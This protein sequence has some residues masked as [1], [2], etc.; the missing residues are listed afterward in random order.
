VC[1]NTRSS[2]IFRSCGRLR[3][4]R[5]ITLR[6]EI[7]RG[8][9]FECQ[10]QIVGRHLRKLEQLKSATVRESGKI[11]HIAQAPFGIL[12][13]QTQIECRIARGR[14]PTVAHERPVD[15]Q[16]AGRPQIPSRTGHETLRH[17][18]WSNVEDIDAHDCCKLGTLGVTQFPLRTLDIDAQGWLEIRQLCMRT[19]GRDASQTCFVAIA[20]P[21]YEVWR[22]ARE[23]GHVLPGPAPQFQH[24]RA[25]SLQ[26]RRQHRPDWFVISVE[27]RCIQTAAGRL[28]CFHAELR[29]KEAT[30]S[31]CRPHFI[32]LQS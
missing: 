2:P 31:I 18:P 32:H 6:P 3:S 15:E 27:R 19:P 29:T 17:P 22:P 14:V 12:P 8:T 26:K 20:G 13:L 4:G 28:G 16:P 23:L 25:A 30:A 5:K 10:D 24:M 7:L 21:P 11:G 9:P 1:S